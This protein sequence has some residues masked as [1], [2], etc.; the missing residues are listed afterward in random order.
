M[1]SPVRTESTI[2]TLCTKRIDAVHKYLTDNDH[3]TIDG[4]PY[5]LTAL[6][7]V[8]QLCLDTRKAVDAARAAFKIM[9]D[10]RKTAD[11]DRV[12]VDKGLRSFVFAKFGEK[13][14]VALAFGYTTKQGK[15]SAEVK[16]EAAKKS[17]ATREARHTMGKKQKK[18]IKGET[19]SSS[20]S[21]QP[22]T[23]GAH[24]APATEVKATPSQQ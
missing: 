8:F 15:K 19:V 17:L 9:L 2:V 10:D 23:P 5:T 3:I 6:A 22:S 24:G 1:A 21:A 7:T 4:K 12:Q 18:H 11:A 13:S 14:E 20:G 16:A